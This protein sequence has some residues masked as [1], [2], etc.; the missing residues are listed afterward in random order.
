MVV[1]AGLVVVGLKVLAAKLMQMALKYTQT[2][3]VCQ[4]DDCGE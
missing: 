2:G 1:D 4:G 3:R